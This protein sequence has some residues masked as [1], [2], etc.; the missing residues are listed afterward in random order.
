VLKYKLQCD[1]LKLFFYIIVSVTQVY[2]PVYAVCDRVSD[3][4]RS[5]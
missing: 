5:S 4:E 3:G 1:A 2:F